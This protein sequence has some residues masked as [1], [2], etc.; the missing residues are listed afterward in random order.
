MKKLLA[1][2]L[3]LVMTL[4]LATVSS[5]AAFT[6]ADSIEYKEAVDVM[7][8]IGVIAGM[9]NGSF[10]PTGALTREQGAKILSYML[11]G[12]KTA[13]D[14]LTASKA[15]FTDV[16][17]NRWSAGAIAY[18]ANAG[19]LAGDGTGKF[20]P[21]G[22]LTG[23]A[24]SKMLLTALGYGADREGLTGAD[25]Q[26]NVARLVNKID[27]ME[28]VNNLL[29]TDTITREQAAQLAFN[30]LTRT[31]VEYQGNLRADNGQLANAIS[32][33]A[34]TAYDYRTNGTGT[35]MA[36]NAL[37]TNGNINNANEQYDGGYMQFCE[38][39]FP[40][41]KLTYANADD[42]VGTDHWYVGN[43]R[44]D[45]TRTDDK[46]TVVAATEKPAFAYTAE[47]KESVVH[48]A[49]ANYTYPAGGTT[50]WNNGNSTAG[51][52]LTDAAIAAY[53]GNG[54]RVEAYANNS[55]RIT[56]LVVV[57]NYFGKVTKVN[58]TDK[59]LTVL[60]N[61]AVS[62]TGE[63][64]Y[65]DYKVDDYVVVAPKYATA[66]T[67]ATGANSDI[68]SIAAVET[69]TNVEAIARGSDKATFE[70]QSSKN[71]SAHYYS[72]SVAA[73]GSNLT[74]GGKYDVMLDTYGY[75]LSVDG[76]ST[77]AT[78]TNYIYVFSVYAGSNMG[79]TTYYAYGVGKDG[80]ILTLKLASASAANTLLAAINSTTYAAT[81]TGAK[82]G[83]G[84]TTGTPITST[85]GDGALN[86][87]CSYTTTSGVSTLTY[88][89]ATTSAAKY[90]HA[91]NS[92]STGIKATDKSLSGTAA[93]HFFSSGM[94][95]I[96]VDESDSEK[97]V[98]KVYTGV[99]RVPAGSAITV[100]YVTNKSVENDETGDIIL[101]FVPTATGVATSDGNLVYKTGSAQGYTRIGNTDYAQFTVY[102]NGE[103]KTVPVVSGS[104]TEAATEGFADYTVNEDGVYTLTDHTAGSDSH[105]KLELTSVY[106]NTITTA[107]GVT[108]YDL[109][110]ATWIDTTDNG[111]ESWTQLKALNDLK[112]ATDG[113]VK[114]ALIYDSDDKEVSMIYVSEASCKVVASAGGNTLT[115][116]GVDETYL[117]RVDYDWYD[118]SANKTTTVTKA[119]NADTT[120]NNSIVIARTDMEAGPSKDT[121]KV[122]VT[123]NG[124]VF[125]SAKT[126]VG[127]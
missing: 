12:G 35:G 113:S 58:A 82:K 48:A 47:T 86:A 26:L 2:V 45:Y 64:G 118:D 7:S 65:G 17:A 71:A 111:I 87:L 126:D 41:L 53:T 81:D 78:N 96:T 29:F 89:L 67:I 44:A 68:L 112:V 80:T 127:A 105:D 43:N 37:T 21:E 9:D 97:L 4:G 125:K 120:D 30:T 3:A 55:G 42:G 1:L 123:V 52:T 22:E 46:T 18:C 121:I 119:T 103:K 122:T 23:Y 51:Q 95:F 83:F 88:D 39:F 94:T 116:T 19:I 72:S 14:T 74:L 24:F 34:N 84:F 28:D 101:A 77:T 100:S 99:Q 20:N 31:M 91:A 36:T 109:S 57:E 8:A 115:I 5:S 90:T 110:K 11:M 33:V 62:V 59:T 76:S 49:M 79:N 104:E 114:V 69:L 107:A 6:D 40:T 60:L 108:A 106:N 38:N 10:N 56:K 13:G 85:A 15:P 70:G 32:N 93:Y 66:T 63:A 25:W 61:G 54:T 75:I 98:A 50:I 92:A 16:A 102:V 117:E 124:Y 73:L 27:L